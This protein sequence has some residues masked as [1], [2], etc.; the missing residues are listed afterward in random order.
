[1]SDL[2]YSRVDVFL[3]EGAGGE[4]IPRFDMFPYLAAMAFCF[5]RCSLFSDRFQTLDQCSVL[6]S[7]L[8]AN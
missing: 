6:L 5:L 3:E 7:T 2:V 4:G 8:G 1:M